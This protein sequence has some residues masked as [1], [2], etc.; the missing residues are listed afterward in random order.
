MKTKNKCHPRML[1]VRYKFHHIEHN[2]TTLCIIHFSNLSLLRVWH[3]LMSQQNGAVS[4]F[5][6]TNCSGALSVV[7]NP[8]FILAHLVLLLRYLICLQ[9]NVL[10]DFVRESTFRILFFNR[11]NWKCTF[12][13]KDCGHVPYVNKYSMWPH[14]Y[15]RLLTNHSN[16]ANYSRSTIF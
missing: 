5:Y 12:I 2:N 4:N 11:M 3:L 1:F 6:T 7:W 13:K 9:S 15:W 10:F 16:H 8:Y 14:W